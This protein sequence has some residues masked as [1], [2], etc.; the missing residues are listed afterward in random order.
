MQFILLA[1]LFFFPLLI[2]YA[3]YFWFPEFRPTGK[4]NYGELVDPAR[5]L[6]ALSLT[7]VRHEALDGTF[8]QGRWTYVVLAGA[9]CDPGCLREL[10]MTRQVRIAMNEKRSRVQRVLVLG[11][12]ANLEAIAGRLR[13]EH[14]D[15]HVLG[16]AGA[17]GARLSDVLQ[18]GDAAAYLVDPHGNWLMVYRRGGE[19]QADFKGMQKDLSKLLR[20]SQIG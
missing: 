3:L 16:E 15:L 6:P 4:T 10:V 19:T 12:P 8:F 18:P 5:P 14:P 9:D 17:V 11:D 13:P 7:N 2:S 1:V 20:L